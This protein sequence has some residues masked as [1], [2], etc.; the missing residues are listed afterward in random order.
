MEEVKLLLQNY[1]PHQAVDEIVKI[2]F[3]HKELYIKI[4][5]HR[6]TKLGDYKKI[7]NLYHRITI[8]HNLNK[9]QFLI[10]L[11]HEIAHFLSFK[12][13]GKNI[14]PHGK[15]WKS[16]FSNLL[17]KFTSPETFPN[18]LLPYVKKYA[19]N[20]KATTAGDGEL[21]LK[22]SE[23]NTHK[24]NNTKFVFQLEPNQFFSL[25]NGT[26][27]QLQEKRRTRYKCIRID[28]QK[29]YLIHQNAEVHPL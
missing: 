24:N 18:D 14:K 7:N 1:I 8:N 22:L 25:P 20:P 10:T 13:Y 19:I 21:F 6:S 16:V 4:T 5:K 23:Y 2:I 9:Y 17:N 11:L 26:K 28:N 15:E 29:I 12:E 3:E 27:Y